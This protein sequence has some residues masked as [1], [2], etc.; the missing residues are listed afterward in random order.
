MKNDSK[1]IKYG[2]LLSGLI[3]NL[4]SPLMGLSGRIELLQ[5]KFDDEKSFNQ[6]NTQI[7]KINDMLTN[8]AYL[9]DKDHLDRPIEIDLSKFLENYFFF[10]N[11][12]TR[13]KHQIEKELNFQSHLIYINPSDLLNL[14]HTIIDYLLSFIDDETTII[15]TNT[16]EETNPVINITLKRQTDID[17]E[18]N[19]DKEIKENL[20]ENDLTIYTVTH[21][22]ESSQINVKILINL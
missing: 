22:L 2:K 9:L 11:T 14:L 7:D 21:S 12:D 18:L 19:I 6:I 1:F 5:M 15:A 16:V 4:N 10:L 8:A 20:L 3:H 17:N 13:F